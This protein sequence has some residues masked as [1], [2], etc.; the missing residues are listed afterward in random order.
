MMCCNAYVLIFNKSFSKLKFS[1][2]T[3]FEKIFKNI[4]FCENSI[5]IYAQVQTINHNL[6]TDALK[7]SKINFEPPSVLHMAVFLVKTSGY[8]IS[9]Y[10]Y[11]GLNTRIGCIET[12]LQ[13]YLVNKIFLNH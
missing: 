11:N 8:Y 1:I 5:I 6:K 12:W 7:S 13:D 2:F 10:H 9:F 3:K 4:K